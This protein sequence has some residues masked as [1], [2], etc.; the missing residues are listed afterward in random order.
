M[1]CSDQIQNG[2]TNSTLVCLASFPCQAP[3]LLCVYIVTEADFHKDLQE[4][5]DLRV[6]LKESIT[7]GSIQSISRMFSAIAGLKIKGNF[8]LSRHVHRLP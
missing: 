7:K 8:Q 4:I 3:S 2:H 5:P 6:Q 1:Q